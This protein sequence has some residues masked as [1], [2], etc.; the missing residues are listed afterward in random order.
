MKSILAK[1]HW[2]LSFALYIDGTSAVLSVVAKTLVGPVEVYRSPQNNEGNLEQVLA[3]CFHLK[4]QRRPTIAIA[5]PVRTV[6]HSTRPLHKG[7]STFQPQQLLREALNVDQS[8]SSQ[9]VVDSF[10]SRPAERDIASLVACEQSVL[11]SLKKRLD[12]CGVQLSV[13]EPAPC[14]LL[15]SA[16]ATAPA[17]RRSRL[18]LRIFLGDKEGLGVL[19]GGGTPLVWRKFWLTRGDEGSGLLS[20][21]RSMEPMAKYC[22]V[23]LP[24]DMVMVHGRPDLHPLLSRDWLEDQIGTLVRWADSPGLTAGEIAYGAA[25]QSSYSESPAFD[26]AKTTRAAPRIQ[27]IMPWGQIA[28][29]VVFLFLLALFHIN[30]LKDVATSLSLERAHNIADSQAGTLSDAKL[31]SEK[32][33]LETRLNTIRRFVASRIVWHS[34][35]RS[36]SSCLPDSTYLVSCQGWN[37]IERISKL[38]AKPKKSLVLQG[39]AVI[40][41]EGGGG[42]AIEQFL[43]G[44]SQL[45]G[46]KLHLPVVE[47]G[48]IQR[49]VDSNDR[50]LHTFTVNLSPRPK[51]SSPGGK[52][53]LPPE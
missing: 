6:F 49:A 39:A 37:D 21:A 50:P 14:A 40:D 27:K 44:V 47:I 33:E 19:V 1:L 35:L 25:L 42:Q 46:M 43:H 4:R 52:T 53:K 17:P 23:D 41:N 32:K 45:N 26:L 11:E 22:G 34:T 31:Q 13:A 9:F 28:L 8:R 48:N 16:N 7:V 24:L 36:V 15:R 5:L 38:A 2:P 30:H 51:K 10:S 29:Q 20:I 18:V 12:D 3:S